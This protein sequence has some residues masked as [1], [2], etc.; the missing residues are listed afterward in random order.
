[1]IAK[2]TIPIY[3]LSGFLGSGKTTML[4]R[5]LDAYNMRGLRPVVLMNELGD[6][7]LDGAALAAGGEA[8]PTAE[9]L[10]GC[11][12]CSIRDDV[13]LQLHELVT[14]YAPDAVFIESTGVAH[15]M[16]IMDAVTEASLYLPIALAGLVAVVDGAFLLGEGAD[17]PTAKTRR[18]LRDQVRC[19]SLVALNKTDRLSAERADRAE[20]TLREWNPHARIVRTVRGNLD[21]GYWFETDAA[22]PVPAVASEGHI[23]GDDCRHGR[24]HDRGD[25]HGHHAAHEHVSVYTRFLNGPIDSGAFEAFMKS[26]P[27]GVYRAKGIAT[28]S[29]TASRFLFQ[30]AYKELDFTRITPQGEVNDVA[31]FL[32]EAFPKDELEA[33]IA[34]L[35]RGTYYRERMRRSYDRYAEERD[36]DE[37]QGW[38]TVER[39]RFLAAL[40]AEGAETLLEVGAGPG[41]D[42]V[43]FRE[44]GLAVTA[45]D[46]S[47]EMVRRCREKGLDALVMDMADLR[48][49]DG[50]F[51][52]V[53]ALNSLLHIPK[54]ELPDVLAGIRRVL[55]PGGLFYMGVY[56]GVDSEGVWEQ[57]EYEPKRFFAMYADEPMRD[58][59]GRAFEI[60]HFG[61]V[62]YAGSGKR[63]HFQSII[64]RKSTAV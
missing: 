59:V 11:I 25:A 47:P 3:V 20:A 54:A 43:F 38:K 40:R 37:L 36:T 13:G 56:G 32:G 29:D 46:L 27:Q 52:A 41:R 58:V 1:M 53:Y 35:E 5:A 17:A 18:L 50:S 4:R 51:D 8:V 15:P 26:L 6:V 22:A 64:L 14:A 9:L 16:E 23:C 31:V 63:P 62:A 45:V 48:F 21:E 12:C 55:K 33:G 24:A 30:Y 2:T 10:G 42:S 39:D 49:P 19:A 7:N 28:F 61:V 60:V 57:D 34:A 44:A